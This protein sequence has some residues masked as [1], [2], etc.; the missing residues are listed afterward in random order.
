MDEVESSA[1][2]DINKIHFVRNMKEQFYIYRL[3]I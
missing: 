3:L 2:F 1:S